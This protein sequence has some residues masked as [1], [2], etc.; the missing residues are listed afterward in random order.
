MIDR[1][2]VWLL[3]CSV[4]EKEGY[5]IAAS[6]DKIEDDIRIPYAK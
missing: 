5:Y 2:I 6:L 4:M 3:D 1:L